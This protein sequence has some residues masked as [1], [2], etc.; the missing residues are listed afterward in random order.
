MGVRGRALTRTRSRVLVAVVGVLVLALAGFWWSSRAATPGGDPATAARTS[1]PDLPA[2]T[3]EPALPG[4]DTV[5]AKPGTV[6]QVAGPFDN[7]FSFSGLALDGSRVSGTVQV[8]SDVSEL[9]D[10]Q[11]V[12]GFYDDQ[13]RLVATARHDYHADAHTE[14]EGDGPPSSTHAF[15]IE[16]P[17]DWRKTVVAAA[18]GVTVLVNE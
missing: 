12:A 14:S 6:V 5:A 13:G 15:S 11:V 10:L 9:L 2:P 3:G 4:L 18:V 16:V 1:F 7:R 8:T 17:T